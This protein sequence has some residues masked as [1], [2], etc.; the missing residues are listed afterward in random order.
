MIDIREIEK[1]ILEFWDK[2]KIYEKSKK[3]N[4]KGKKFYFLQG[5][6]Y[7]SGRLHI[8]HAWNNSMKDIAMRYFR[9]KGCDVWDRAGYD[10][11][12]L[13]TANKVQKEL[14]LDD[15]EAI[16][17]FGLDKFIKKCQEFST[18]NAEQ[19]NQDLK[20]LGIWMDFEN[21]YLP[22]T[23][24]FMSAEW[25]LIKEAHN[26]KRLYKGNKIMH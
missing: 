4:S 11:H 26:Q 3:K 25:L 2:N 19:M 7:T 18:K 9:M 21:A 8:G 1:Q 5:P 6:P 10:M 15:K 13:P 22:V 16:L 23:N 12:G 20:R 14:N 24:E 17:K